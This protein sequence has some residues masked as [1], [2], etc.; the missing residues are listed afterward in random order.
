MK[1]ANGGAFIGPL[2]ERSLNRKRRPGTGQAQPRP[3]PRG[4]QLGWSLP[5]AWPRGGSD[6]RSMASGQ[7]ASHRPTHVLP[8]GQPRVHQP[9]VSTGSRDGGAHGLPKPHTPPSNPT[10]PEDLETKNTM[11]AAHGW[12][13]GRIST[14]S[15]T[16]LPESHLDSTCF[17][18]SPAMP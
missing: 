11:R 2:T 8:I 10:F 16:T 15:E 5:L 4:V 12:Q 3:R 14:L 17:S 18:L 1:S 13:I 7:C 9:R 6:V